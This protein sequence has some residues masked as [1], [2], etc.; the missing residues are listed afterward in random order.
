MRNWKE[1]ERCRSVVTHSDGCNRS[2]TD[3]AALD[4]KSLC[5]YLKRFVKENIGSWWE[6]KKNQ[7]KINLVVLMFEKDQAVVAK[8][9]RQK[10]NFKPE[11]FAE[12]VGHLK[13]I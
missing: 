12:K 9:K 5:F 6:P 8:I 2:K 1:Y 11:L 13:H 4:H 10:K 7:Y 3:R